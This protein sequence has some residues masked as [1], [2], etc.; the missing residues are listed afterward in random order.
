MRKQNR[1]ASFSERTKDALGT[2]MYVSD[3]HASLGNGFEVQQHLELETDKVVS[4]GQINANNIQRAK[5]PI[6]AREWFSSLSEDDRMVALAFVDQNFLASIFQG[7]NTPSSG[8]LEPTTDGHSSKVAF[9]W[10]AAFHQD[11]Y[12][13][14]KTTTV[15]QNMR[16]QR[17][18]TEIPLTVHSVSDNE[19]LEREMTPL[20]DDELKANLS[21][22]S[23]RNDFDQTTV[24]EASIRDPDAFR[25]PEEEGVGDLDGAITPTIS[26][27][28]CDE[29]NLVNQVHSSFETDIKSRSENKDQIMAFVNSICAI[30]MSGFH[31]VDPDF[32]SNDDAAPIVCLRPTFLSQK[33]GEDILAAFDEIM[34]TG[35]FLSG[36]IHNSW[37]EAVQSLASGEVPSLS[38]T[39]TYML[40]LL[41]F[42]LS[43]MQ[44]YQHYLNTSDFK[45]PTLHE[46]QGSHHS[47]SVI[48]GNLSATTMD[49]E[50]K[51]TTDGE[52]E[53]NKEKNKISEDT[54]SDYVGVLQNVQHK[55][56][57]GITWDRPIALIPFLFKRVAELEKHELPEGI[58]F[59]FRSFVEISSG[60]QVLPRVPLTEVS[61]PIGVDIEQLPLVV[62]ETS[63][64]AD[65][66]A[67]TTISFVE[68]SCDGADA[69][70]PPQ[71][72]A[73]TQ[74]DDS[75][76]DSSEME[77]SCLDLGPKKNYRKKKR[78]KRR[79]GTTSPKLSK[80]HSERGVDAIIE[81]SLASVEM[82]DGSTQT[83]E[84]QTDDDDSPLEKV[85]DTALLVSGDASVHS[86]TSIDGDTVETSPSKIDYSHDKEK[87]PMGDSLQISRMEGIGTVVVT[88]TISTSITDG[89]KDTPEARHQGD[90]IQDDSQDNWETV[91]VRS[92]GSRKK[93]NERGTNGR[94]SS[95]QSQN[96]NGSKRKTPRNPEARKRTAKR[97]M[98]R[99]ILFSVLDS[100]DEQV[101]R[102]K[103][104]T[105]PSSRPVPNAW[106]NASNASHRMP[107]FLGGKPTEVQKTASLG[108]QKKDGPTMRDVLMGKHN[109]KIPNLQ[110]PHRAQVGPK[111]GRDKIIVTPAA[112]QNTAPTLPETLSAVSTTSAF[113]ETPSAKNPMQLAGDTR[114]ES[115]S[116]ESVVEIKPPSNSKQVTQEGSPSPPL[117]TLLS[118]G[119][120]NSATSSVASSLDA[121]HAV[122]HNHH[123]SYPGNENDVGYHLL[124][125]CDRL[126][127]DISQF[128]RRR[129]QALRVRRHERGL[130]LAALQE[131]LTTIWPDG[132]KV[133]MYGSCAT[134]LDLP[135][136]DLD[137]VV[138]GLDQ[139]ERA[140]LFSRSQS[141]PDSISEQKKELNVDTRP[142]VDK[143]K[144]ASSSKTRFVKSPHPTLYSHVTTNAERVVTLA[145]ELERQPWAVHVKAIP[146]AT[147]PV[148]KILADPARLQGGVVGNSD[149]LVH[150]VQGGQSPAHSSVV[151][152]NSDPRSQYPGTQSHLTW[153]GADVVNGLLK[154]DITFEGPEHGG[155]GSTKFSKRV[156]EDFSKESGSPPDDTAAVQV[157]MVLKELLA[158]RRLNEP[159]SGGLSS[160]AL[161]LLVI[162]VVR[163]RGIIRKELERVE[164]HRRLVAG[165]DGSVIPESAE[166]SGDGSQ[167]HKASDKLTVHNSNESERVPR[168]TDLLKKTGQESVANGDRRDG[169]R[170]NFHGSNNLNSQPSGEYRA[171]VES[172]GQDVN[173]LKRG[174]SAS[175]SWASIARKT[176]QP[177]SKKASQDSCQ[178]TVS[179]ES[180]NHSLKK[181]G[182][183][184]DA[185]TKGSAV[186]IVAN[187]TDTKSKDE[188]A[189]GSK[190]PNSGSSARAD[191]SLENI[192]VSTTLPVGAPAFEPNLSMSYQGS[193]PTKQ[194][195]ASVA[196]E[197]GSNFPQSFHDVIE[198]LCS[199]ET[200]S[201]KLLMHFLLFYGQHFDSH[202]TAIDY[203][204]THKRDAYANNG[205]AIASPYMLRRNAGTYD[206]MTG[207]LTV[208]PI[209]VY[210]PL[211][212]AESNNVARSCFAWSSIRWVFAQSY[213]TLSSAV[214]MSAGH[215]PHRG[216][217]R[218]VSVSHAPADGENIESL[219][220]AKGDYG[221]WRGQE[222]TGSTIFDPATPLLEL[223]LAF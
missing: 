207:M 178:S 106:G 151:A 174:G 26:S 80:S 218:V 57:G 223:L 183:F 68:L 156:V 150:Q 48:D 71:T 2:T 64:V 130:V 114:S 176:S 136:S 59:D 93:A 149:W 18:E 113:T 72:S 197:S 216:N 143:Q 47:I 61:A 134:D 20:V 40:L 129:E 6:D 99:E 138:C 199:G 189:T 24:V 63:E 195:A 29:E 221:A 175:S 83:V 16:N 192:K 15:S 86:S 148:I 98:V 66:I 38:T 103:Q 56:P 219:N 5:V 75:R 186:G 118:P 41:R 46:I 181:Q 125:V 159:F 209:V 111:K 182:S 52:T 39:P 49:D 27:P 206:A 35:K 153:R 33:T 96:G 171:T 117:P 204:N 211:E 214:E 155:I 3:R 69:T 12:A 4:G 9:D 177:I 185:V 133:E 203:S 10:T 23:S 51:G 88:P 108:N 109:G 210:D 13:G 141:L 212:G 74:V 28:C 107:S 122:H 180:K 191:S 81:P 140:A 198:V 161:L 120:A 173:S 85:D 17:I 58:I 102:R 53:N 164:R 8:G 36:P 73:T 144:N 21:I 166:N 126:T 121:P 82:V 76:H 97:K 54:E 142:F 154:V 202:S 84:G 112:D 55:S 19:T 32:T 201:G 77:S 205:Y 132:C 215:F 100:V 124:R 163:E 196:Y 184:A 11:V 7:V 131:S 152:N 30:S 22:E 62:P 25:I 78:R 123:S 147:V 158:Q 14:T 128:M 168:E 87:E 79:K 34:T 187:T 104:T 190:K 94:F 139:T 1:K 50:I 89:D 115:S 31:L 60:L 127:R 67:D 222:E 194:N 188:S 135:S 37:N 157:L 167:S 91:E 208:D 146:T 213:M 179:S 45:G 101:R 200:T 42:Q 119:N 116:G 145:L 160:Y 44:S 165:G 162:S 65:D 193:I 90:T 110:H 95:L 43:V 92:R 217:S 169:D 220:E 137:V 172:H 70:I 105:E 170:V